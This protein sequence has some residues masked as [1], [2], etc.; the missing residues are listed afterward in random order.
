MKSSKSRPLFSRASLMVA[1]ALLA[2][3]APKSA[4]AANLTWNRANT[5][6]YSW[7]N[8]ANWT[9]GTGVPDG[10][11]DIANLNTNILGANTITLDANVTLGTLN[12]GDA[13]GGDTFLIQAGVISQPGLLPLGQ[14][15]F[16]GV[17]ALVFDA[18]GNAPVAINKTGTGVTDEIAAL[19]YFNDALTIT[20][21][22]G[23]IRLSGGLRSGQSDITIA[24][25]GEVE[26]SS[27]S[28]ITGG[29][30]IM[31]GTGIFRLTAA[32]SYSGPTIVNAGTMIAN[33]GNVMPSRTPLTVAAGA[34]FDING[35]DQTVGS[36]S[37][38]GF[39]RNNSSS[40]SARTI[41]FGRDDTSTSFLG[42]FSATT[43]ARLFV[44][45]IGDGTFTFSPSA[46]S[47]YT[48]TTNIQGGTF[49][50]DFAN[51]GSLTSLLAATPLTLTSGNFTMV[52]RSGLAASQTLGNFTSGLGGGTLS[53]VPGDA[54]LTTRLTLGTLTATADGSS[55]RLAA[56]ANT[57]VTTTTSRPAELIYGSGRAVFTDGVNVDWLST[58]TATAPFV[59]GGMGTAAGA[60]YTGVL[61]NTVL[62]VPTGNYTLSGA[63]VQTAASSLLTLKVTSTAASQS[64]A[65]GAFDLAFGTTTGGLLVTG[66]HGYTISGTT[67]GLRVGSNSGE[68]VIHQY[69]TGG[70]TISAPI[71]NQSATTGITSLVKEG[72]G[73]LTL[74]GTNTFTGTITVNAGTLAF[75]NAGTSGAGTLGLG[76]ATALRLADGAVLRY[77]GANTGNLAGATTANSHPITLLGGV[78]SID[79]PTTTNNLT[80][81]AVINGAGGLTKTGTGDLTLGGGNGFQGPLTIEAGRVISSG[82]NRL[83]DTTPVVILAG[84]TWQVADSDNIGALSGAGTLEYSSTTA[85]TVNVGG[86]NA[87]TTF[88]GRI[89]GTGAAHNFSK[90]GSGVL[91]LNMSA[92]AAPSGNVFID[93]GVLRVATGGAQQFNVGSQ[94]V[95]NHAGQS[96]IFDLNGST[97]RIGTL[98]FFNS[99][100]TA[101]NSQGLVLLNG[102]TLI[103]GG[104]INV[105][106]FN[107]NPLGAGI[108]GGPGS[109]LSMGN[110]VRDFNVR[111]SFSLAPGEADFVIDAAIDGGGTA[112]GWVKGGGG[113][114][115]IKGLNL[116]N[117]TLATRFDSGLTILDYATATNP[118]FTNRL[119]PFGAIDLRGG[120]VSLLGNPDFDISQTV[121]GLVL[122]LAAAGNTGGESAIGLFSA[123][124]RNLVLNLGPITQ[125]VAGTVRFTLPSGSQSPIN[126]ITTTTTNDLF[127]GLLGTLGAAATV[128]DSSGATSFATRV[129]TNIVPISMVSRDAVAGVLNGENIT[130]VTGYT[131]SLLNVVAPISI[132][133]N[134]VGSSLLSIPDG[135]ILKVI[136]GGVL[137]TAV[138]GSGTISL[139]AGAAV[140]GS[141]MVTV[142][143]TSGLLAGMPIS[144][145]GLPP[146]AR[147]ARVIDATTFELDRPVASDVSGVA[148][149]ARAITVIQGGTLRSPT[150]ELIISSDTQGWAPSVFGDTDSFYPTKRLVITSSIDGQQGITKT[151]NG[152]LVLRAGALANDFSGVVQL[153]GGVLELNRA[154]RG[155]FAIGDTASLV[156]GNQD[157]A[158]FRMVRDGVSLSGGVGT[159]ALASRIIKVDST[160]GLSVGQILSGLGINA[161]SRVASLT[162]TADYTS[163]ASVALTGAATTNTSAVVSVASTAGLVVGQPVT[164]A[165]IPPNAFI[166]DVSL[167]GNAITLS[168]PATAT[169]PNVNLQAAPVTVVITAGGPASS[170]GI[171]N[172]EF[173]TISDA[174]AGFNGSFRATPD[175]LVLNRFIL[176]GTPDQDIS[177]PQTL[178][179]DAGRRFVM[180]ANASSTAGGLTFLQAANIYNE[181]VGS[182]SGGIRLTN[183]RYNMIDLGLGA[184]LTINQTQDT[185]FNGEFMGLGTLRLTG[186]GTLTLNNVSRDHG[187]IVIDSGTLLLATTNG[188]G[189]RIYFAPLAGNFPDITINRH[190]VLWLNRNVNDGTSAVGDSTDIRLN[191]A[192][193]TRSNAVAGSNFPDTLPLGFTFWNVA[194]GTSQN[195]NIN[196][197]YF[198]SG[199]NY[200]T[201]HTQGNARI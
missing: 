157:P 52:G 155:S 130:D 145:N 61:P 72:S 195:E 114:L 161:G 82:S 153:Q 99:P 121:A 110:A 124:G 200:L 68:I 15:T 117:G 1:A 87:N 92:P 85:R 62:N 156:F 81:S 35:N 146:G 100:N 36:I 67:G 54:T 75:S 129:G 169:S 39:I 125:R 12:I 118:Q 120:S 40:T 133:F 46:A 119:N 127:T 137:Q 69:N 176:V 19:I 186:N 184:N 83:G 53:V 5:E 80:I 21:S 10:L 3:A 192:A 2:V 193:G 50:L 43:A 91:T 144:G 56:P 128:T 63:Q 111:K 60:A 106:S 64:L 48:G 29:S 49:V 159:T 26:I 152:T 131:G 94:V 143:S 7:A 177:T 103:L 149:T 168:A 4:K 105:N 185:T 96:A 172:G 38:A 164:G 136:S 154:G 138:G 167:A 57:V 13:V 123:N 188:A 162:V 135:G 70:L 20:A 163:V 31:N 107:G 160:V 32:S 151:G 27:G 25:A 55:L 141:S 126:G 104:S 180:S 199:T 34:A 47:N 76:I 190:G 108:I 191:S 42:T 175:P 22:A 6:T 28:L 44:T 142:T 150:R 89:T 90:R 101:S 132:R 9:G 30:V 148:V 198:D 201:L 189:G 58:V 51:S 181:T 174:A 18:D 183:E 84:A 102:G 98:Q 165:G 196:N 170:H 140:S 66:T 93:G 194:G 88:S 16:S 11:G 14:T 33:G 171:A 197:L 187:S 173:V 139:S 112:G 59:L 97:Q 179:I 23:K 17:G 37:G 115:L 77:T 71:K 74:S 45:K 65:L 116:L 41:T 95:V 24:G 158:T 78:A 113:T 134:A 109:I 147:V 178:T 166:I 122:P 73:L 79:I 86:D 8:Q 182:L